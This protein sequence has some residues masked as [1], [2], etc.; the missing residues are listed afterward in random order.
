MTR[1]VLA[2]YANDVIAQYRAGKPAYKIAKSFGVSTTTTT[3]FLINAGVM[4]YSP[5]DGR[6][7]LSAAD[8]RIA[9]ALF[10]KGVSPSD[11]L[12]QLPRKRGKSWLYSVFKEFECDLQGW[13]G[14]KPSRDQTEKQSQT[15]E[16]RALLTAAE[17][18]LLDLLSNSGEFDIIPQKST[19]IHNA[20]FFISSHSVAV[21]LVCRGSF[22]KYFRNGVCV[23]R[24]K[25]FGKLGWHTYVL[26]TQDDELLV[27]DGIADLLIWLDFIKRQPT[28]RRQYRVIRSPYDLLACGCSDDNE[29]P[30]IS[31]FVHPLK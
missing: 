19:G 15:K 3:K 21:E 7:T 30:G 18:V 5:R 29:F 14:W 9:V 1:S 12:K 28:I 22:I 4:E 25:E 16:T 24:I 23:D 6:D 2:P 10:N 27:K 20:D 8:A 26:Y 11:I 17:T 13:Y 31:S